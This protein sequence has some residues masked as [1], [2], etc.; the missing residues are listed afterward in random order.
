[1]K[2]AWQFFQWVPPPRKAAN[3][4]NLWTRL[5]RNPPPIKTKANVRANGGN[6]IQTGQLALWRCVQ[7]QRTPLY[8]T[9]EET[10]PHTGKS[11]IL[12]CSGKLNHPYKLKELDRPGNTLRWLLK[13]AATIRSQISDARGPFEFYNFSALLLRSFH[14]SGLLWAVLPCVKLGRRHAG[15]VMNYGRW[16]IPLWNIRISEMK[17]GWEIKKLAVLVKACDWFVYWNFHFRSFQF[18][19]VHL[20]QITIHH[21]IRMGSKGICVPTFYSQ[22]LDSI[23]YIYVGYIVR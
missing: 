6:D 8:C 11:S 1:V 7:S 16:N 21:L 13:H 5:N 20:W 14:A 22:L 19:E 23:S 3:N 17:V 15:N 2:P 18:Q 10:S 9:K 12:K 4:R